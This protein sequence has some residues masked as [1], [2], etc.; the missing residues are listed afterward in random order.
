MRAVDGKLTWTVT[1]RTGRW[2]D[3]TAQWAGRGGAVRPCVDGGV[4][5]QDGSNPLAKPTKAELLSATKQATI[6]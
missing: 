6:W 3:I 4:W 5:L 1:P 2:D